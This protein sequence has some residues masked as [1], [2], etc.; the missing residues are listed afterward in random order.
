MLSKG[1]AVAVI[2]LF[3]GVTVQPAIADFING[4]DFKLSRLGYK[5][6]FNC[7]IRTSDAIDGRVLLFPGFSLSFMG[8]ANVKIAFGIL[9]AYDYV[10]GCIHFNNDKYK[11]DFNYAIIFLFNG[12]FKNYFYKPWPV[13]DINGTAKFARVCYN[14]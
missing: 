11:G 3:L 7:K 2:I 13:I 9:I 8:G 4:E 5:N 1:L 14:I 12:F 6:Y 10:A